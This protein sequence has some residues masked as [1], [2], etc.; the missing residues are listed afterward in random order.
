VKVANDLTNSLVLREVDASIDD[1]SPGDE[2]DDNQSVDQGPSGPSLTQVSGLAVQPVVIVVSGESE[3]PGLCATWSKIADPTCVKIRIQFRKQGDATPL[4]AE[5]VEPNHGSYTWV[6]GVQGNGAYEVRALPV[7]TPQRAADWT[8]WIA[9][10]STKPQVVSVAR[11]ALEVPPGTIKPGDLSKQ[12]QFELALSSAVTAVHGS[13]AADLADAFDWSKRA[14]EGAILAQIR[15]RRAENGIKVEQTVRA[16]ANEAM[17]QRVTTISAALDKARAAIIIEETARVTKDDA[18]AQRIT[19]LDSQ[20]GVTKAAL[21]LEE[22]VRTSE[23]EALSQRITTATT[24]LNGHTSSISS[25]LSSI[26]GISA[27]WGVA[28]NQDGQVTG[29]VR[30]KGDKNGVTFDVVA[31]KFRV[32]QPDAAGG[33]PIPVFTIGSRNGKPAIGISGDV[34]IDGSIA[35]RHLKVTALSAI[36]ADIGDIRAGRMSSADGKMVID[37]DKKS[38][39]MST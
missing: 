8:P 2:I 32:A 3:R 16:T 28:I 36:A 14:A 38:I 35:A 6:S 21:L 33:D 17:S 31:D 30:L 26:D 29:L 13:T 37:L 39:V 12:A 34:L 5:C 18:L 11:L 22:K 24:T 10:S 15:A 27:Q 7:S 20:H 25:M 9:A 1:W 19:L 23:T 4:E